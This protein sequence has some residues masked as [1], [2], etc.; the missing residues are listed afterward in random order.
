MLDDNILRI[1]AEFDVAPIIA[2]AQQASAAMEGLG[3]KITASAAE[4]KSALDGV[5]AAAQSLQ[6]QSLRASQ[7]SRTEASALD[8]VARAA[9]AVAPA[10][11]KE[12]VAST[13]AASASRSHAEANLQAHLAA[14]LL[15]GNVA[16]AEHALLRFATHTEVIGPLISAAFPIFAVVAFIA[17]LDSATKALEEATDAVTGWDAAAK[18]AFADLADANL[19]NVNKNIENNSKLRAQN[20]IGLEG[21]AKHEAAIK[22]LTT[23]QQE[24]GSALTVTTRQINEVQSKIEGLK[25]LSTKAIT[26]AISLGDMTKL[27]D[28]VKQAEEQ[29]ARLQKTQKEQEGKVQGLGIEIPAEKKTASVDLQKQEL[30]LLTATAEKKKTITEASIAFDESATHREYESHRITLEQETSQ[31]VSEE[32]RRIIAMRAFYA[33]Q[34][35]IARTKSKETGEDIAPKLATISGQ[36]EAEEEKSRTK[37]ADIQ[38]K[39]AQQEFERDQEAALNHIKLNEE[40]VKSDDDRAIKHAETELKKADTP[41]EIGGAS[42]DKIQAQTKAIDDQ[43]AAIEEENAVLAQGPKDNQ[44]QLAGPKVAEQV[45]ANNVKIH[46][47]QNQ[48]LTETEATQEETKTR[49]ESY[50]AQQLS[51]ASSEMEEELRRSE[52]YSRQITETIRMNYDEREISSHKY[53]AEV[54]AAAVA[55]F[56]N[57]AEILARQLQMVQAEYDAE[58]ISYKEYASRKEGIDKQIEESNRRMWQEINQAGQTAA[59]RQDEDIKRLAQ[60]WGKDWTTM[61]NAV[62][63]HRETIGVAVRNM[64]GQIELQMIDRGIQKIV[65]ETSQW[66]IKDVVNWVKAQAAKNAAQAA[67]QATGQAIKKSGEAESAIGDAKTAAKGAYAAVSSIPIIGPVLAPIAA[68]TAFAAVLA[69]DK[70]GVVPGDQAIYAHDQEMVLPAPISKA[71]QGAVPAINNFNTAMEG[72]KSNSISNLIQNSNSSRTETTNGGA[73]RQHVEVNINGGSGGLKHEDIIKS[74]QRGIRRGEIRL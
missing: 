22:N 50:Y 20:E 66:L 43:I 54:Q 51:I 45:A 13:A 68:A 27:D 32:Q 55:E 64:M 65:T 30:E 34:E 4:E 7:S 36:R 24:W 1:G 52:D 9:A 17:I 16:R 29:L 60:E 48:L 61:A 40:A 74:V 46:G 58:L 33:E 35:S 44:G 18:K 42:A 62:I 59:K 67:G 21:A 15:T 41:D 12:A 47:L 72:N 31:L 10:V 63:Q 19:E 14:D 57:E 56:E 53:L 70:G 2:G 37:I 28:D 23:E 73:R 8:A 49:T 11:E 5:A 69:F 6:V 25:S 71:V 39:G 3:A 38:A 26:F